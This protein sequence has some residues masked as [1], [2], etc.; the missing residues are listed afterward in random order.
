MKM[1]KMTM[2]A[3]IGGI[4][5]TTVLNDKSQNKN[6]LNS[7]SKAKLLECYVNERL[8]LLFWPTSRMRQNQLKTA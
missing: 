5:W 4:F 3:R 2:I 7:N 8:I 1:M 6:V